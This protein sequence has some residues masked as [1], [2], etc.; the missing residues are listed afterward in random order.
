MTNKRKVNYTQGGSGT[1][2][3]KKTVMKKIRYILK[4]KKTEKGKRLP[5]PER[6][7]KERQKYKDREKTGKKGGERK[8]KERAREKKSVRV[9]SY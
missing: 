6:R 2:G 5:Y 7:E 4:E 8:R 9:R 1:R 3:V